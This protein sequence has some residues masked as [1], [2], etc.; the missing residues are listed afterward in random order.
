MFRD[1]ISGVYVLGKV[2]GSSAGI[3]IGGDVGDIEH[4]RYGIY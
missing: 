3:K 4:S 1:C 2:N